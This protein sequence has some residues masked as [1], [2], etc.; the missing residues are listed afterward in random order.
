MLPGMLSCLHQLARLAGELTHGLSIA[1]ALMQAGLK[2]ILTV[3]QCRRVGQ[4]GR[5]GRVCR[6]GQP[7]GRR[8]AA[9]A[10][11]STA[12]ERGCDDAVR[13]RVGGHERGSR[14]PG[15]QLG[16]S[17]HTLPGAPARPQ[18]TWPTMMSTV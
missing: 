18:Q 14:R 2:R 6:A 5:Q 17:G 11:A 15:P 10:G 12:C 13:P 8:P 1:Q 9:T 3:S 4:Q 16:G 7:G